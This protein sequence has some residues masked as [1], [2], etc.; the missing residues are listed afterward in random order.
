MKASL[1][2]VKIEKKYGLPMY[3]AVEIATGEPLSG[4]Q[5]SPE[6]AMTRADKA[7]QE[8]AKKHTMRNCMRCGSRFKSEGIGHRL[9]SRKCREDN[10][11]VEPF[12]VS[13]PRGRMADSDA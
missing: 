4:W 12:H 1:N 2:D 3:R 10:G 5:G 13:I 7:L 8:R 11:A 6:Q 9:C